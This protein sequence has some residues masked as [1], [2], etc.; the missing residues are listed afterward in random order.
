MIESKYWF[1]CIDEPQL[2]FC[3][4]ILVSVPKDFVVI[5]NGKSSDPTEYKNDKKLSNGL[6]TVQILLI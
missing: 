4:E 1:P 5:S 2:K 3:R 6:K